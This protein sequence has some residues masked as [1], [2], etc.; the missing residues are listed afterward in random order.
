MSDVEKL[1]EIIITKE[2]GSYRVN[3][4]ECKALA[5]VILDAGYKRVEEVRLEGL[6]D[7]E[8]MLSLSEVQPDGFNWVNVTVSEMTKYKTI[9]QAQRD[10]DMKAIKEA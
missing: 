10:A 9:A 6:T 1:A 7:E 4:P 5:Q 3:C 8:V 2:H